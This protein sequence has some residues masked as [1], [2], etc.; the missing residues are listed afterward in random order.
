MDP[1]ESTSNPR[2]KTWK[3]LHSRKGREKTGLFLV[4]GV[5]LIEEALK[6]FIHMKELVIDVD[7]EIPV[8]WKVSNV[9]QVFVTN[10]VMKEICET[11]TPQ[12]FVAICEL[13][14]NKNVPLERGKFLFLDGLQD[15]GNVGAIIRTADAAGINGVVLGEG[16]VDPFNGKVIRATQGSIFHLPVQRMDLKEAV[17]ICKEKNIPVFG[18]S[19]QGSTY[20]AI[21]PQDNFALIVG[22]EGSGVE[23]TLLEMTDQNLYIPIHGKAESLNVSIATGIL[24]YHLRG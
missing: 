14:D 9:P 6:A 12:G 24:L 3:K 17:Q 15:P 10:K 13:P 19:L 2:V 16:T 4:E 22:N 21:Q 5:H 11:E 7:K 1:I 8:E 20:N 23:D 18:T